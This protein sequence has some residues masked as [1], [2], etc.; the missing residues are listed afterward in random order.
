M[1]RM[2]Q[3]GS[4][5][6]NDIRR[7]PGD[8]L[9]VFRCISLE[10]LFVPFLQ[11][12]R[13]VIDKIFVIQLITENNVRERQQDGSMTS[14]LDSVE[15]IRFLRGDALCIIK[16]DQPTATL[17]LVLP[18]FRILMRLIDRA[19]GVIQK[20]VPNTD[21]QI[22]LRHLTGGKERLPHHEAGSNRKGIKVVIRNMIQTAEILHP[23]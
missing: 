16:N 22:Q 18:E 7:N 21:Q 19:D 10:S 1:L 3:S 15:T 2:G 20:R 14:R 11:T 5:L 12:G 4:N 9:D 23:L 13:V 8:Q 17:L 6:I